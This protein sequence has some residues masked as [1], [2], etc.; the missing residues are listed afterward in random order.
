M[1]D[2]NLDKFYPFPDEKFRKKS[3]SL[4]VSRGKRDYRPPLWSHG[5]LLTRPPPLLNTFA[6]LHIE[7]TVTGVTVSYKQAMGAE[8][9][10]EREMQ[11]W[12]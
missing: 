11:S 1:G 2:E 12:K 9:A 10:S 7:S 6:G 4:P 8:V 5:H 3:I